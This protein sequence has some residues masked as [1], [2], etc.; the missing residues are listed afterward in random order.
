MCVERRATVP[1]RLFGCVFLFVVD[2]ITCL[3]LW[4][5]VM[6][7]DVKQAKHLRQ[8]SRDG[9]LASRNLSRGCSCAADNE[10]EPVS[11]VAVACAAGRPPFLRPLRTRGEQNPIK[12]AV[13][14]I[15]AYCFICFF[16]L[17]IFFI[18][19]SPTP[20]PR[21]VRRVLLLLGVS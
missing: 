8:W 13:A 9:W 1:A 11:A 16:F 17:G 21:V 4:T 18:P 2:N 14:E 6:G 10:G 15:S 5:G 7:A 12:E 19:S 20:L 3:V